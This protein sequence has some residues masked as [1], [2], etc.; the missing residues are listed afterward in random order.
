MGFKKRYRGGPPPC[1]ELGDGDGLDPRFDRRD[2]NRVSNRKALQLC[3]QVAEALSI[4]LA[5]VSADEV[6]RDLVVVS[7][8]PAPSTARL[9]VSVTSGAGRPAPVVLEHLARASGW[10]RSE[11]AA[12][13]H[14]RR[15]PELSFRLC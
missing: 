5:G 1:S 8:V 10:L 3:G 7:V 2:A 12:A 14:R 11:V 6:L 9:L 15:A 4:L 13:V